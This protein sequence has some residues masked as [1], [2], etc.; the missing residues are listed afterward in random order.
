MEG[1]FFMPRGRKIVKEIELDCCTLRISA[2]EFYRHNRI[3]GLSKATQ[4]GYKIYVE[5]FLKWCNEDTYTDEVTPQMLEDYICFKQ[6]EGKNN[7]VS[8]AT[9]MVHL[10]RF[11]NFCASRNYMEKI[12]VTIPKFEEKLKEPYE[13]EEI[14]LLL[15]RPKSTKWVEWR[16]WAMANYYYST[17]QRLSTVLNIKLSHLDL[18]NARVKLIWNKDKKQKYMPLS[19]A[20]IK[21]LREYIELSDLKEHDYLFPH[22]E[23]GKL[24]VRGAQDSMTEY[25]HSRGVNSTGT[26]KYRHTFAKGYIQNG[27]NAV[28]LQKLLNHKTIEQTMKYVNMYSSDIS[29]DLDTFN[30]L[31]NFKRQEKI[32]TVRK[33]ISPNYL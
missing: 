5:G 24:S 15:A 4:D 18:D 25:N 16:C 28:K 20:L 12:E 3:K 6:D 29:S 2:N 26:H 11:F 30:P 27:G 14:K 10:R 8:I 1:V 22:Y 17:G 33:S 31:D 21:V 32:R 13:N 23:G 7:D 9:I 19:S